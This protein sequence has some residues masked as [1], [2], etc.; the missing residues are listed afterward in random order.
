VRLRLLWRLA[1]SRSRRHRLWLGHRRWMWLGLLWLGLGL[2]LGLRG[3]R[4]EHYRL[5]VLI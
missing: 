2:L 1:R 4:L 5:M 3:N